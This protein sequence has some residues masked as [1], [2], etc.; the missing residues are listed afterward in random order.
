MW[1]WNYYN[2]LGTMYVNYYQ[3]ARLKAYKKLKEILWEEVQKTLLDYFL[4]I[5]TNEELT[6]Y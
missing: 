6:F 5:S 4:E 1:Y 3:E 2:Y